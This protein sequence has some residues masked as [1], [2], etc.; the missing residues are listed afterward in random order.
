MAVQLA[1]GY[2]GTKTKLPIEML[3]QDPRS[4]LLLGIMAVTIAPV[5]EETIFRGYLYPV[6]ARSFGVGAG[7]V[8]T[9]VLFG[10]LHAQQLWGGWVQ[11]GLLMVVGIVFT[12]ARAVSRTVFASFLLHVSYNLLPSLASLVEYFGLRHRIPGH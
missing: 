9:G 11:I 7:V 4:L 8:V 5:V 1:A 6:L 2:A 3:F 10:L 12:F